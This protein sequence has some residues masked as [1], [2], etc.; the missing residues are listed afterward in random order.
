MREVK[1]RPKTRSRCGCVR[2]LVGSD[3]P[4]VLGRVCRLSADCGVGET[5]NDIVVQI[6]IFSVARAQWTVDCDGGAAAD[7][8]LSL[9]S[10]CMRIRAAR[11]QR[12]PSPHDGDG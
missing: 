7:W 11:P 1:N 6:G 2:V 5:T 12:F 9:H 3:R 4:L 8:T 10:A